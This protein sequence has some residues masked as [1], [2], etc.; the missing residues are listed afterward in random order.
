MTQR[1]TPRSTSISGSKFD[2]Y[3]SPGSAGFAWQLQQI[4]AVPSI[5]AYVEGPNESD[6][7]PQYY[8]GLSGLPATQAEMQALYAS[9][10]GDAQLAGVPVIQTSFANVSNFAVYGAQPGTADLA[11]VHL[12]FGTGNNPGATNQIG[13]LVQDAQIVTPGAPTI[14]TEAGYY[15]MQGDPSGVSQ[16]VQAKYMLDLLF[17]DWNAGITATVLFELVDEQPDPGNTTLNDHFGLF[18]TDW[19]PKPAAIALH[20]LMTILGTPAPA[21]SHLAASP[22]RCPACPAPRTAP[23]WK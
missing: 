13:T 10:K 2:F 8:N 5:V 6:Y 1:P 21:A 9:V 18:N 20:N 22:T 4:E 7:A 12:Y 11:N 14:A 17:D 23:C 16:I 3:I 19:T 15:T